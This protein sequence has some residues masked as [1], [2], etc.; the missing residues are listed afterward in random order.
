MNARD[1]NANINPEHWTAFI[2]LIRIANMTTVR[3]KPL[4]K[5][6]LTVP[7]LRRAF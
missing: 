4:T 7:L 3:H 6:L 5:L 1:H 2:I